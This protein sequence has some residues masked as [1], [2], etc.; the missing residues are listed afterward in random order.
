MHRRL[1]DGNPLLRA[2]DNEN[3]HTE[4]KEESSC[5]ELSKDQKICKG[6]KAFKENLGNGQEVQLPGVPLQHPRRCGRRSWHTGEGVGSCQLPQ[7]PV[8]MLQGGAAGEQALPFSSREN[9]PGSSPVPLGEECCLTPSRD[10]AEGS[11]ACGLSASQ[12]QTPVGFTPGRA[13]EFGLTQG[14]FT[15]GASPA[16]LKFRRRAGIGARGSPEN[17]S[18]IQFLAQQRSNRQKE[19]LAQVSPFKH[20]RLLKDKIDTFQTCFKAVEEETG[21]PGL[22]RVT[23]AS[24]DTGSC[25]SSEHCTRDAGM[26]VLSDLSREQEGSPVYDGSRLCIS[27]AQPSRPPWAE[28]ARSGCWLPPV[29]KRTPERQPL[30][31]LQE[32]SYEALD[33]GGESL[34]VSSCAEILEALQTEETESQSSEKPKKKKVTF[35]Q[36]LSPEIFDEAL[37]ANAP[38]RRGGTPVQLHR[39][40]S[41][42]ARLS[43]AQEPLPQP[44]FDCSEDCEPPEGVVQDA[45]AADLVPAENA[46]AA[47][48]GKPDRMRTRSSTKRKCSTTS[49]GTDAGISAATA[50]ESAKD[51]RRRSKHPDQ[52]TTTAA[53]KKPRKRKRAGCVG[54]RKKVKASLYGERT[55]ASRKPLLSPVPEVSECSLSPG[56]ALFPEDVFSGGTKPGSACKDVQQK[57]VAERMRGQTTCAADTS[58][59][60]ED[61]D[62][63]EGSSS[64]DTVLQVPGG[65]L[66][67][68]AGTDQEFSHTVPEARAGFDTSDCAPQ[69]E[70]TARAREAEESTSLMQNKRLEGDL[71]SEAEWVAGLEVLEQDRGVHEGAR[72]ALQPQ[73]C[74]ARGPRRRRTRSGAVPLPAFQ[75]EHTTEDNLPLPSF[76][77]EEFLAAPLDSF[78]VEEFLSAPQPKHD[79]SEPSRG[80]VRVRRSMRLQEDAQSEGL[81]WLLL[82]EEMQSCPPL[83]APARKLR[84]STTVLRESENL[85]HG[86]Q[87]LSQFPAAGK[88]NQ[89]SAHPAAACQRPRRRSLCTSTPR[90][91]AAGALAHRRSIANPLCRKGRGGQSHSEEAEIPLHSS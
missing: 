55:M 28:R 8:G 7:C 22:P 64:H 19:A 90:G 17:N 47:E 80:A 2:Q 77:V 5:P 44:S 50:P 33:G 78:N 26:N 48:P 20:V 79:P 31:A 69:G 36:D 81:A 24:Q 42:S 16:S 76:H 18:L 53:A 59:S 85:H 67:S 41:P 75:Q 63:A 21:T 87:N 6:I 38:L 23:E 86:E 71:L 73:Q 58:G 51:N 68:A 30:E 1:K 37:P 13:A 14:N 10:K 25:F 12:G 9:L 15:I 91:A 39:H 74:S 27:P 57:P 66:E 56:S 70:Q 3:T 82:P 83:L 46:E 29:P 61:L 54:R 32:C 49:E 35:G 52:N 65:D 60:S 45:A 40:S 4:E 84:R 72:G 89:G 34:A 62:V 11:S 43:L 88:E